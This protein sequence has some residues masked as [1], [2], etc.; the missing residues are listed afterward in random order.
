MSKAKKINFELI[1]EDTPPYKLLERV[2]KHHEPTADAVIS[3]AWWMEVATDKDGHTALGKCVKSSD[4]QREL[5]NTDFV[6]L[7]NREI[8]EDA[9]FT[10]DKR[11]ALLD[12][13]LSHAAVATDS[14]GAQRFDD[15]GRP[16]W[17]IRK[18]DIE[19]FQAVVHRH[20][21]WKRDLEVFADALTRK[22]RTPLFNGA[23]PKES[24]A[25]RVQ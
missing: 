25:D 4:L 20:G 19:E 17:R 9:E 1:P 16:V 24:P 2:R 6:I 3:L 5:H 23:E 7:L 15:S 21:C 18:H 14:E 8:W 12:H 13:E 22:K 11:R 10:D